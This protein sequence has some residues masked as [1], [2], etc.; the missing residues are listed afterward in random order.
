MTLRL[1]LFVACSLLLLA[2]AAAPAAAVPQV[3]KTT[4]VGG[5]PAGAEFTY[6]V[7]CL[8]GDV[9]TCTLRSDPEYPSTP[10]WRCTSVVTLP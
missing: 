7:G 2:F 5:V 10:V 6:G 1:S 8:E 9:W 3:C 4:T